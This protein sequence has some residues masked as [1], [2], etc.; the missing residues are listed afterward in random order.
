M[1]RTFGLLEKEAGLINCTLDFKYFDMLKFGRACH[2][3]PRQ[4]LAQIFTTVSPS[5]CK[6]SRI[7]MLLLLHS[8]SKIFIFS[9]EN[10][11]KRNLVTREEWPV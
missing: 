7:W 11:I 2:Q 9:H 4:R 8:V 6:S 3:T 1:S 10:K 5:V